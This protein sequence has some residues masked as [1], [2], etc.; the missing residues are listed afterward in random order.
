MS[1]L[2]SE[3]HTMLNILSFYICQNML[4]IWLHSSHLHNVCIFSIFISTALWLSLLVI[5]SFG[6]LQWNLPSILSLAYESL[7][8][9]L[10]LSVVF[11]C[12]QKYIPKLGHGVLK[13]FIY[14]VCCLFTESFKQL[15][16]NVCIFVKN[17][18]YHLSL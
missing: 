4:K 10:Y 13:Y 16:L 7:L 9:D 5:F 14:S 3:V 6:R 1:T 17:V 2:L 12:G 8:N 11:W 18:L 15:Y